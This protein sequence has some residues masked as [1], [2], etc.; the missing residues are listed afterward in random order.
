MDDS[1]VKIDLNC[2][3]KNARAITGRYSDYKYFIGV[4]KSDGYGHGMSIVN[5]LYDN[6]INYFA[7]ATLTE[8]E[9]LRRQ[10]KTVPPKPRNLEGTIKPCRCCFLNP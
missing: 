10:N 6:G 7:V 1:L 9:E 5:T 8:A 2:L 4:V 3:A